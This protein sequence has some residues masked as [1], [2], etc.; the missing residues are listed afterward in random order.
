MKPK[1]DD[2]IIFFR[3]D[4]YSFVLE[5]FSEALIPTV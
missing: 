5:N 2:G 4:N 3:A 1:R